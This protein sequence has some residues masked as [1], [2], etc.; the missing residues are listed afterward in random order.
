MTTILIDSNVM[1]DLFTRDSAWYDWSAEQI[2]SLSQRHR[3]AIN[4]VIYGEIA[5]HFS[6][7][8]VLDSVLR[9]AGFERLELPY[10]AAFVAAKCHK[11]YRLQGGKRTT[12]LPDFFI[13]AHA[14]VSGLTL[15]TR[16]KKRRYETCFPS[17][18]LIC[19]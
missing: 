15:L 17:V 1:I 4:P 11:K 13:G 19:P 10:Q 3:L 6:T 18:K 16:D 12:T 7:M 5:Y 2:A 8:D 14:A 9:T